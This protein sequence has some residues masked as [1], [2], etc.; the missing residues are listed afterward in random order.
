MEYSEATPYEKLFWLSWKN[1]PNDESLKLG[2]TLKISGKLNY[3]RLLKILEFYITEIHKDCQNYFCIKGDKLLKVRKINHKANIKFIN[4][5]KSIKSYKK[6]I[7]EDLKDQFNLES[8]PLYSFMLLK[9]SSKEYILNTSFSHI[10]FD[11]M[12][13]PKFTTF[14]ED[15]YNSE[16]LNII[17]NK[18]DKNKKTFQP[19]NLQSED[20]LFWK[21][22]FKSSSFTQK[23]RF[24]K[25][26]DSSDNSFL[27]EKLV[28]S[29]EETKQII[30]YIDNLSIT[31]F[32]FLVGSL[33][34]LIG[35]Y[36]NITEEEFITLGHTVNLNKDQDIYGCFTNINPLQVKYSP[37]S[38]S[39]EIMERIRF[40]RKKAKKH[41]HV[42]LVEIIKNL[43]LNGPNYSYFS[44]FINHSP[45]LIDPSPPF[46]KDLLTKII[47]FPT[48]DGHYDL[49]LIYSYVNQQLYIEF[50]IRKSMTSL[51]QLKE[52]GKNFK[53]IT[54]F[55]CKNIDSPISSFKLYTKYKK[56]LGTQLLINKEEGIVELFKQSFLKNYN[57]KAVVFENNTWLYQDLEKEVNKVAT[58]L[59]RLIDTSASKTNQVIIGIHLT[60]SHKIVLAVLSAIFRNFCFVPLDPNYPLERLRYIINT[61]QIKYILTDKL[62]M[63]E[64]PL[65]KSSQADIEFINIDSIEF[66]DNLSI[67]E[68]PKFP[69]GST[70]LQYILFTSGSTGNPKGVMI[71]QKNLLNFILS[72]QHLNICHHDDYLLA[73]TSLNFD[74]SLLEILLP[75]SVGAIVDIASKN[76]VAD[77][78]QL[79]SH[80]EQ[81]PVSIIQATPSTWRMLCN[82]G[83]TPNKL[84]K[85]IVGGENFDENLASYLLKQGHE[86]YNMY[87]PTETTIW[88]TSSKIKNAKEISIGLPI[89]NTDLYILDPSQNPCPLGVAGEL[90]ISGTGVGIGYLNSSDNQNFQLLANKK[91][92]Y[93]TGDIVC[94]YGENYIKFLGRNDGQ[95][96]IRG[97]RIEL[98]DINSSIKKNIDCLDV[99]TVIRQQPE[100]HLVSFIQPKM[101]QVNIELLKSCLDQT[102]PHYMIP[103]NF[104]LLKEF[105]LTLNLKIDV[106]ILQRN[107]IEDILKKYGTPSTTRQSLYNPIK[108][109]TQSNLEV[110]LNLLEIISSEFQIQ[111]NKDHY[112]KPLGFFG[113]NSI[114]FNSLAYSLQ[115]H[116]NI[117]ISPHNF[118]TYDTINKLAD[119]VLKQPITINSY[120]KNLTT[121][122]NSSINNSIAIIGMSGVL[123]G[124]DSIADFWKNLVAGNNAILS[125]KRPSLSSSVKAGFINKVDCF[126]AAFFHISPLEA[127]AMDP[128]QRLLLHSAWQA[129][130]DAGYNPKTL[131]NYNTGVYAAVTTCDYLTIQSRS[132]HFSPV[133]YTMPGLSHSILSNRLSYFFNWNGPSITIDTACSGSLVALVR[134]YRDLISGSID[135]ALVCA[136]NVILDQNIIDA[137]SVGNFL[138]PNYRCATF[139]EGADGYVRGEGVG[140]VLLKRAED[141][142]R[143]GD[144]CYGLIVSC[145]ENH[146]GRS[147]SLTAPNPEAQKAL[148][149]KAYQEQE[150][151]RQVSYI[152]AHGT[153]TKLGDP[154]E[155]DALK[156]AW[157]ELGI[158]DNTQP[159]AI[160]SVKT[161]IGH[162]EP[163]AGIASLLKVLLCIQHKTLPTNLHF[164]KLNPYIE[165]KDSPFYVLAENQPWE[166][167]GLRLAGISSFGFGGSNAHIVVQEPPA[168]ETKSGV[169]KKAYLVC[170]S[171]K[172]LWSLN[173]FKIKLAE[174]LETITPEDREYSLANIAYTLNIGRSH[175]EYRWVYVVNN[176]NDLKV[177]IA[178]DLPE[179]AEVKNQGILKQTL[180]SHD[181]EQ[182]YLNQLINWSKLYLQG[183]DLPWEDL[184]QNESKLRLRLPTYQ[185]FSQ[186]FWFENAADSPSLNEVLDV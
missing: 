109:P 183:Y 142:E 23:L 5:A 78:K 124:A 88:S 56:I 126:D 155:I 146:G 159:V 140:C 47:T 14:L 3:K 108:K 33:S 138:S 20:F 102:L 87:G 103:Q 180:V 154:I 6:I 50:S 181:Q 66:K 93:K 49:G 24:L 70:L 91:R 19:I 185:F 148:L 118:Y 106:K 112:D 99:I 123:P 122:L 80:I 4:L 48:T 1:T 75:L 73:I 110:S 149:V 114:S 147:H 29:K 65:Y 64:S 151:A 119:F 120:K 28:F 186:P 113:F 131:E 92:S 45:G 184:H 179:I 97:F 26:D 170:I 77:S 42:P 18:F 44:I 100:P 158:S 169:N 13:Y 38:T 54:S 55:F 150:L 81:H 9:L 59:G 8:G 182:D 79:I 82:A 129:L 35:R 168:R 60:R 71:S 27:K 58:Y 177:Q 139:D 37:S 167:R 53:D 105:P 57:K 10:I 94:Y 163:A 130:E 40:H 43:Q 21:E 16:N 2:Y 74:I 178:Q 63:N 133:P 157:R 34:G 30:N 41:Q 125:H 104:F 62:T 176:I 39:R 83:W 171:A 85:I 156:A 152:E 98:N 76:I 137:L 96:K 175:F 132:N 115:K 69:K 174:K 22:N 144:H 46:L 121:N 31:L 72:M 15:S 136:A 68:N 84:L 145:A 111:I 95:I 172:N 86:I 116:F 7:E 165:L 161:N 25:Q 51:L 141:A 12:H 61:A 36:N 162:L 107:N 173:Q 90:W 67:I 117:D 89:A 52:L 32:Q 135:L 134:A 101:G 17:L 128:Q 166:S 11:G 127:M 143:D 160:G 153:G 164:K